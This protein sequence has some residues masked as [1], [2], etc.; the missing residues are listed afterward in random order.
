MFALGAFLAPL[1]GPAWCCPSHR[2]GRLI[3]LILVPWSVTFAEVWMQ[4]LMSWVPGA[5]ERGSAAARGSLGAP[6]LGSAS[7]LTP[8]AGVAFPARAR[9]RQ[10]QVP[11]TLRPPCRPPSCPPRFLFCKAEDVWSTSDFS[12][13]APVFSHV[14]KPPEH[15]GRGGGGYRRQEAGRDPPVAVVWLWNP[16]DLQHQ[17]GLSHPCFSGQAVSSSSCPRWGGGCPASYFSSFGDTGDQLVS[18]A[19]RKS[20]AV[21]AGVAPSWGSDWAWNEAPVRPGPGPRW[22]LDVA[23]CRRFPG[24]SAL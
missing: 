5:L 10:A 7:S 6:F 13:A 3:A 15:C 11:G 24:G 20:P 17:A 2:A 19:C 12:F 22:W 21:F 8:W 23:G 9:G 14:P 1:A 4:S 18:P 16:P